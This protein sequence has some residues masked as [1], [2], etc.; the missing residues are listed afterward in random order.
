[1]LHDRARTC[2][3]SVD[4][5]V[6][7][8]VVTQYPP[9]ESSAT[10]IKIGS[11]DQAVFLCKI[12]RS[13]LFLGWIKGSKWNQAEANLLF[14]RRC[15]HTAITIVPFLSVCDCC[16]SVS[17]SIRA[18]LKRQDPKACNLRFERGRGRV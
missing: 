8:G 11:S 4:P 1:M 2:Y 7:Q 12:K 16:F 17:V 6:C 10:G 3:I 13:R 5:Q 18:V 15:K 14:K 9:V